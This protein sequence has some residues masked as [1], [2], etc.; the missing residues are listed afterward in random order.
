LRR[1]LVASPGTWKGV[2]R[3]VG[4]ANFAARRSMM[5]DPHDDEWITRMTEPAYGGPQGAKPPR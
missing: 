2:R 3:F 4:R 5:E 1:A